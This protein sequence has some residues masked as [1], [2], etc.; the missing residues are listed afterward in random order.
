MITRSKARAIQRKRR[1]LP[2]DTIHVRRSPRLAKPFRFY[3]QIHYRGQLF[4][5]PEYNV[6]IQLHESHRAP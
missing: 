5:A 2:Y 1:F 3:R 4:L 6:L